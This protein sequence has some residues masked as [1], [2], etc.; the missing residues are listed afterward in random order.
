[1]K[2]L[3]LILGLSLILTACASNEA[4]AEES[5]KVETKTESEAVEKDKKE[6]SK[7]IG[8][9]ETGEGT[10]YLINESGDTKEGTP[11]KII[12]KDYQALQ[13]GLESEG[14]DGSKETYIYLDGQEITKEQMSDTQ[15]VLQLE[16][17]HLSK[18]EH[19]VEAIQKDGESV[20]FYRLMKYEVE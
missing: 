19:N 17:E 20:V 15:T 9:Q 1:M 16:K 11:I 6:E 12:D 7:L 5:K 4:P 2:K 8:G 18:G 10:I 14:M 3:L 13:I